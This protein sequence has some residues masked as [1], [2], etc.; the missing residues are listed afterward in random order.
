[1]DEGTADSEL[2]KLREAGLKNKEECDALKREKEALLLEIERLKLSRTTPS[3]S[4][5]AVRSLFAV[6]EDFLLFFTKLE[7]H[8]RLQLLVAARLFSACFSTLP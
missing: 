1:M 7:L 5:P 3:D 6:V 2:A 8:L 4:S